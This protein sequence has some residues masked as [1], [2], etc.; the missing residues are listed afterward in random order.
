MLSAVSDQITVGI[1]LTAIQDIDTSQSSF[2]ADFYVWTKSP[3]DAP[4]PLAKVTVV[5]AK[6]QT[7]LNEWRQKFSDQIW[8]LRKYRCELLNDWDLG[9]FPFDRHVLAIGVIPQSDEYTSPSYQVDEKYSGMADYVAPHGWHITD[10]KIFSQNV[11]YG[12]NFGDPNATAPYQYNAVTA[13]FLLIREPWRLFF[14]LMA[15][16]YLAAGAAL[17]GCFMKTNHPPVFAGR[18]G[19]QIACLFAAIINHR[20]IGNAA[21]QRDTFI[22]PDALQLLTYVLIFISLVLTLRSR[23]LNERNQETRALREER[24]VTLCLAL[25][26]LLLN[27]ALVWAALAATPISSMLR[28]IQIGD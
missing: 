10:F 24:R 7:T 12:S 13:S 4:D 26:F 9:N 5:R 18:I 17:L 2:L 6:T 25:L 27:G 19:L 1:Y 28:T 21:G 8:S 16:A 23:S 3:A 20:E 22:L 15:G 11:A 14:K